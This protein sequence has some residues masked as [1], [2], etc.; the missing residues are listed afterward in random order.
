MVVAES[1]KTTREA[2]SL[3]RVEYER[4]RHDVELQ[5]DRTD[6]Y[7]P[8][9]V[10]P[11]YETDTEE[12]DPD[13]ALAAAELLAPDGIHPE[14]VDLRCLRPL[15]VEAVVRSL[16]KTNRLLAV[17]EGPAVGGW[18]RGLVGA[19]TELGLEEL[20]DAA[21]LC[22]PDTPVPYSP[23]LEDDFIPGAEAIAATVRERLGVADARGAA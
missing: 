22:T 1:L 11:A 13:A 18:A 20:D 14:V 2:A 21:T 5:A 3:V 17:E 4:Q 19:V 10:N 12:G 9:K 16:T 6:L 8:D 15:D 23:P 7:K